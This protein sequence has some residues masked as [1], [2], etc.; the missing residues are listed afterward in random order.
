MRDLWI[1]TLLLLAILVMAWML[2]TLQPREH[3][4]VGRKIIDGSRAPSAA[5]TTTSPV[6]DDGR[7]TEYRHLGRTALFRTLIPT[8]P[9]PPPQV[10]P[11]PQVPPLRE[12][13]S[14]RWRFNVAL[15]TMAMWTD[16]QNQTINM[17]VG[18]EQDLQFGQFTYRLRLVRI[19]DDTFSAFL[20]V[21]DVKVGSE[22]LTL[23][24]PLTDD[25]K[26]QFSLL[27]PNLNP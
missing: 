6:V 16:Q 8:P 19:D 3:T 7:E 9:P 26:A 4:S 22:S 24:S 23:P 21:V 27:Y 25:Y 14:K 17:E 18:Q 10:T 15:G 13:L 20:E 1:N 5:T 2:F 12:A 11:P